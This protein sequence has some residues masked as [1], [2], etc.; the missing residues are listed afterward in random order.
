MTIIPM[1]ALLVSILFTTAMRNFALYRL[2]LPS[3]HAVLRCRGQFVTAWRTFH[4][5]TFV[6]LEEDQRCSYSKTRIPID[7]PRLVLYF[8]NGETSCSLRMKHI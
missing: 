6:M 7:D 4:A 3:G 5:W 2:S 8:D 1:Y